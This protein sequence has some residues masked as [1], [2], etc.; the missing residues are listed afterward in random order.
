MKFKKIKFKGK[1]RAVLAADAVPLIELNR[2]S[3]LSDYQADAD[4]EWHSASTKYK[5]VSILCIFLLSP[6]A[7]FIL[8]SPPHSIMSSLAISHQLLRN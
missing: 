7:S 1:K 8:V 3:R 5:G 6:L 4:Y 2:Y